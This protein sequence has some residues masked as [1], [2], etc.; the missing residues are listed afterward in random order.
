MTDKERKEMAVIVKEKFGELT[1][2]KLRINLQEMSMALITGNKATWQFALALEEIV[3]QEQYKE[4][5]GNRAKFAEKVGLT[6]G[7]IS[8]NIKAVKFV[9][10]NKISTND[11]TMSRAYILGS[12]LTKSQYDEFQELAE[13]QGYNI[14]KMTDKDVKILLKQYKEHLENNGK[15]DTVKESQEENVNT[16]DSQ[17]ETVKKEAEKILVKDTKGNR[18]LIPADI[19]EMYLVK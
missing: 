12:S 13:K 6:N 7:A 2:P 18:Y 5:F 9:R 4:D 19:L 11:I 10:E 16:T 8:Q 17:E 3:T 15:E 14:F 1:N